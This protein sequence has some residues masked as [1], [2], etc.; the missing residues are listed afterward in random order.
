MTNSSTTIEFGKDKERESNFEL[1]RIIAMFFIVLYHLLLFFVT[2]EDNNVLYRA[3]Y[4]PLHVAVICF[5]LI[6]GYFH[7]TPS[8]KGIAKIILPL[9]I[10][11]IPLTIYEWCSE[12]YGG[13]RNLLF[14]SQS[15]YWFVRTYLY[16]YLVAPM[17]NAYLTSRNHRTY[18]LLVLGGISVYMGMMH[19]K[20]L[21]DGKN[22]T[23]FMFIYVIGDYIH[24]YIEKI[25][26]FKTSYLAGL[27]ILLNIVIIG[28]YITFH[29]TWIGKVI[30]KL[31]FPYCSP[32]LILNAVL[33]FIVFSRMSF[34]SKTVNWM[35][36]SVFSIYIL[37]H[38]HFILYH[39]VGPLTMQVYGL[40]QTPIFVISMLALQTAVL[41][42]V[43]ILTDKLSMPLQKAALRL[44]GCE[45]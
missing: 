18:M 4:L 33:L 17:L 23:L 24:N 45:K 14:I 16:L 19:D 30:W 35:S 7:I 11:Y 1:L 25:K 8:V 32:I 29:A 41:M 28:I 40:S 37:H 26:R 5:V 6:S 10:F 44:C 9:L 3:A 42:I 43:F 12:N 13:G 34:Q 22:L 27:Y 21:E 20:S 39:V 36:S 31:S 15:P 2:E 38:Q